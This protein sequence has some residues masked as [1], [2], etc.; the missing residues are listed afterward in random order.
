MA[1]KTDRQVRDALA[2]VCRRLDWIKAKLPAQADPPQE[3][4]DNP[5]ML[6][7]VLTA[8]EAGTDLVG[9]LQ[10]LHRAMQ[11]A[12]DRKGIWGHVQANSRDPYAL[13][14][15]NQQIPF[16]PV[17]DCPLGRCA[18]RIGDNV[19]FPLVCSIAGEPLIPDEL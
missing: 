5:P 11:T 6:E 14:G 4:G 16:E 12:G 1:E 13:P 19:S 3:S 18:G 2:Y 10:A 8:A 7:H 15:V 17:Y 9:P